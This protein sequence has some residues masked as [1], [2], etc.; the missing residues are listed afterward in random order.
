MNKQCQSCGM[1]LNRDPHYGG[2]EKNGTKSKD[3][4][5]YC[6][7]DGNFNTPEIDSAKKMQKFCIKKMKEQ[8]TPGFIAWIMTRSIPKLKRWSN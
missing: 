7:S 8:G 6:Y 4:C 3:Y 2:T 1:P 5:S